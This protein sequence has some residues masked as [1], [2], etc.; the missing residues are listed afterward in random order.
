[1]PGRAFPVICAVDVERSVRFYA[2]LGFQG[3][4]GSHL[5]ARPAMSGCAAAPLSR[6]G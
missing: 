3:T 2:A 5:T 6:A 4:F 1:M